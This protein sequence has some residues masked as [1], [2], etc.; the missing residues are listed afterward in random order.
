MRYFY[1]RPVDDAWENSRQLCKPQTVGCLENDD[2]EKEDPENE[3]LENDDLEKE[4]LENDDLESKDLE[5]HD[6]ENLEN[7]ELRGRTG[8]GWLEEY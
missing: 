4:D 3:D 6:L 2:L 5:N 7:L 8:M 1:L